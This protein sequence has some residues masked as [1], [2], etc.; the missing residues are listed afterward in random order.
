MVMIDLTQ[1]QYGELA[2]QVESS[3]ELPETIPVEDLCQ[4][5]KAWSNPVNH[6]RVLR[7]EH[8]AD[9][10]KR[11]KEWEIEARA[12]LPSLADYLREYK[13]VWKSPVGKPVY[14]EDY[15]KEF[16]VSKVPLVYNP[17][18]PLIRGWDF[19]MSPA[20]VVTQLW[21]RLRLVVLREVVGKSVGLEFLVEEV[22]RLCTEWFPQA[23]KFHDIIDPS[24]FFRRDNSGLPITAELVGPPLRAR[25]IGGIQD[26]PTRRKSV[27]EFLK[28]TVQGE[29][30]LLI[31]PSCE[32]L[33]GGFDG[34]FHHSFQPRGGEL[35]PKWEKN[36]YSHIHEGLQYICS[37]V[38]TL[39]LSSTEGFVVAEPR[40][41]GAKRG[42]NER[43]FQRMMRA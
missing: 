7:L 39:N 33:I 35:K 26:P 12:G 2:E 21:P 31:D 3:S 16:H 30:C 8:I 32:V 37:K 38:K 14:Q 17:E 28:D 6:F 42:R 24:G 11:S 18:L 41:L 36:E 10:K 22:A 5:L 25:P 4:G 27:I 1:A 15:K 19:G 23:S 9:P 29:P 13:L 43:E 40:Y 34:G 20:C